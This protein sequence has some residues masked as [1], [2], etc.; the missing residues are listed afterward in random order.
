MPRMREAVL[1]TYLIADKLTLG[2]YTLRLYPRK[3]ANPLRLARMF[4]PWNT[5]PEMT[6]MTQMYSGNVS[7]DNGNGL[8]CT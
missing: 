5:P 7:T 2:A 8:V 1:Q 6:V 4:D 3:N